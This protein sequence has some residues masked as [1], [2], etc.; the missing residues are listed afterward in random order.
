MGNRIFKMSP[1]KIPGLGERRLSVV[2]K[3][4]EKDRSFSIGVF[5]FCLSRDINRS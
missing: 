2:M 5:A 3:L 4:L 1:Q